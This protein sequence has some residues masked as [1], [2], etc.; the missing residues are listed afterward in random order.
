MFVR[1]NLPELKAYAWLFLDIVL[2]NIQRSP[3]I[4]GNGL[5]CG[6]TMVM[7]AA[8]AGSCLIEPPT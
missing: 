1:E 4:A 3:G 8:V 7:V 5:W 6:L 2:E